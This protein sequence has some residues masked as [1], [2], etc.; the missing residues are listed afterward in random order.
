M[1]HNKHNKFPLNQ[2][3][4][5]AGASRPTAAADLNQNTN[6]FVPSADEVARKAYFSYVNEGSRQG[7]DVQHWLAAEAE[8]IAERNLTRVHGY[9]NQ[10]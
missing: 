7:H 2:N 8:L 6:R 5:P 9:H 3:Q 4:L 1:K 10:T